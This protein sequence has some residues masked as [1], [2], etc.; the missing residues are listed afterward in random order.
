MKS[1]NIKVAYTSRY[2][3]KAPCTVPQI[4]MEGKWLEDI[5][6]SIGATVI[7]EYEENAIRIRPLT[8]QELAAKE[9]Q[10]LQF[11]LNQKEKELRS[12]QTSY[13]HVSKVAESSNVYHASPVKQSK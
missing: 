8:A 4:K 6:F 13:E 11:R 2:N 9:Q 10:E 5:G 1:K 3:Q 7:I 12:L